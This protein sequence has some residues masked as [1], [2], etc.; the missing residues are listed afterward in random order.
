MV[1]YFD[2]IVIIVKKKGNIFIIF[3]QIAN[4]AIKQRPD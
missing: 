1:E 2:W 3:V 4:D